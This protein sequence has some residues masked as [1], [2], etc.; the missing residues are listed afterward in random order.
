[1]G[2]PGGSVVKKLPAN[3]RDMGLIPGLERSPRGRNGNPLQYSC[4]G[5]L[6]DR[7]TLWAIE[8]GVT[9]SNM[10]EHT[11]AHTAFTYPSA[12]W[13]LT[14][15]SPQGNP[16]KMCVK[17]AD[18]SPEGPSSRGKPALHGAQVQTSE[19]GTAHFTLELTCPAE[20]LRLSPQPRGFT[21][22]GTR[23]A[24]LLTAIS[25]LLWGV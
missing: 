6:M 25:C 19:R 7:G 4:L 22:T 5:N 8:H 2:F 10:T 16:Q 20:A 21:H 9:E 12:S 18:R 11:C 13:A 15:L 23:L 1:M 24:Q 14:P 3:A 17:W